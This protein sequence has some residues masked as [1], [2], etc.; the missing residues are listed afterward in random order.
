MSVT[1]VWTEAPLSPLLWER[2]KCQI[3]PS[4]LAPGTPL[5]TGALVGGPIIR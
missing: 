1:P 2:E 5:G 3:V 4:S